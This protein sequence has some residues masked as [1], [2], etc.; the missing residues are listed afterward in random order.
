MHTFMQ[1]V[2]KQPLFMHKN[3]YLHKID[4]S[5]CIGKVEVTRSN[6][7]SSSIKTL[8]PLFFE[9]FLSFIAPFLGRD[10]PRETVPFSTNFRARIYLDAGKKQSKPRQ[11]SCYNRKSAVQYTHQT[12]FVRYI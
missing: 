5:L 3:G 8:K 12:L 6:R 2:H 7:V 1:N 9:G 4:V 10:F 11:T